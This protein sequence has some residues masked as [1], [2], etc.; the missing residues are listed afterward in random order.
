MRDLDPRLAHHR[1]G[2]ERRGGPRHA[3]DAARLG[4][5]PVLNAA[6]L[7]RRAG[8]RRG[9]RSSR[10]TDG[11]AANST[12]AGRIGRR[13]ARSSRPSHSGRR[14]RRLRRLGGRLYPP[15]AML[16][17]SKARCR[18]GGRARHRRPLAGRRARAS[19]RGRDPAARAAARRPAREAA[20]EHFETL[21][22]LFGVHAG[23]RHARQAT[24]PPTRRRA[25]ASAN[26]PPG[27]RH[28]GRRP[29]SL[30]GCSPAPSSRTDRRAAA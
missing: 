21:L 27:A 13:C 24:S 22:G 14:Q 28:L 5:E 8:G 23:L 6:E 3:E 29:R 20:L 12:R 10:C 26:A 19:D 16:A 17:L 4:R 7:A 18:D 25:G 11:R 1:G 9:S 15:P 30:A 2:P